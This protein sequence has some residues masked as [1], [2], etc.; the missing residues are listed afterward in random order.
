M[1]GKQEYVL[2][3]RFSHIHTH[4]HTGRPVAVFKASR[5]QGILDTLCGRVHSVCTAFKNSTFSLYMIVYEPHEK[6]FSAVLY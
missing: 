1:A 4:T 2:S 6:M 5:G 3:Q